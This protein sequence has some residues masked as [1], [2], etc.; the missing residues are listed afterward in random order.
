MAKWTIDRLIECKNRSAA[1]VNAAGT[2]VVYTYSQYSIEKKEKT[3]A[4][5]V[6]SLEKSEEQVLVDDKLAREPVWASNGTLVYVV[7]KDDKSI[8]KTIHLGTKQDVVVK[9]FDHAIENIKYLH[10]YLTYSAKVDLHGKVLESTKLKELQS[11]DALIYD[12]L[13][14]RHWDEWNIPAKN[15]IFVVKTDLSPDSAFEA[16]NVLEGSDLE[17]PVSP[18][19]G[20]GDYALSASHIAFAAKDPEANPAWN[21]KVNI[22]IA[23]LDAGSALIRV[24]GTEGAASLPR[25]NAAGT[26]LA[27]VEM[28]TPGYEADR[29]QIVLYDL[30]QKTT[31][32]VLSSWDRSPHELVWHPTTDHLYMIAKEHGISKLF[33]Y[34]ITNRSCGQPDLVCTK[35]DVAALS[36]AVDGTALLTNTSSAR[37]FV[38]CRIQPAQAEKI[39]VDGSIDGLSD[40]STEDFWYNY[41]DRQI[42]GWLVKPASFD[43]AKKYP[44]LFLIHGGPQGSWDNKWFA[45]WNINTFANYGD[46]FICVA[47]NPTGSTSY[48]QKFCDDIKEHWGD[49]PYEDLEAGLDF[50]LKQYQFIDPDRC[51]AAGASYG[52]YMINWIQGHPLGRRFKALVCHDGIFSTPYVYYSGE[53]LF[54]PE[55][56]FGGVPWDEKAKETYEKWN[57]SNFVHEWATPE[58]VIHGSCDYRLPESEGLAAFNALQRRGIPSRLLIFKSENHFV[59]KPANSKI[60][61]ETVMAWVEKWTKQ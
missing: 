15:A 18:F 31:T 4:I 44:M 52:G 36:C 47:I 45:R 42:H 17:S 37:Q 59:Q 2:H 29:N 20:P 61:Y 26:L 54:F 5:L 13:Y 33:Y 57:P 10:G 19:G 32:K 35:Y 8:L 41:Q 9:A 56:D 11:Q 48:G 21:T 24:D 6:Y 40:D 39:I 3:G 16:R 22:Y 14:A 7:T 55:R 60:W 38:L 58:L 50:V 49:R 28:E 25:F 27:F 1:S 12:G 23:S 53:E 46:G 43:P 30:A 34:D 51:A